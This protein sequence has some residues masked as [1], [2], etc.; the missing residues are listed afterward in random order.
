[1][2]I[3]LVR[4]AEKGWCVRKKSSEEALI[5]TS[6]PI[7]S[8]MA[9]RSAVLLAV[10]LFGAAEAFAPA[11]P[12]LGHREDLRV[13]PAPGNPQAELPAP[14]GGTRAFF[15]A[16]YCFVCIFVHVSV[17]LFLCE[18]NTN[19]GFRVICACYLHAHDDLDE[20]GGDEDG[21]S[22]ELPTYENQ[23]M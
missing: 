23:D 3:W 20:E 9:T 22:K 21:E 7:Q 4:P 14:A 8:H 17:L 12:A 2:R 6:R 11:A 16:I 15:T 19:H 13:R 18:P 10:A 5:Y 1:M